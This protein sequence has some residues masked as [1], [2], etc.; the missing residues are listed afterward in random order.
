MFANPDNEVTFPISATPQSIETSEASQLRKE[1]EA[2]NGL[3]LTRFV[4]PEAIVSILKTKGRLNSVNHGGKTHFAIGL[5]RYD[6]EKMKKV[7]G[8]YGNGGASIG[9]FMV[10]PKENSQWGI[11]PTAGSGFGEELVLPPNIVVDYD[12]YLFVVPE[13]LPLVKACQ[14]REE[15]LGILGSRDTAESEVIK[16]AEELVSLRARLA[17]LLQK[18]SSSAIENYCTEI[19]IHNLSHEDKKQTS[20]MSGMF[21]NGAAGMK[22]LDTTRKMVEELEALAASV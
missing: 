16:K 15:A 8:S 2:Q 17:D 22:D 11:T 21:I 19:L 12:S 20:L 6:D 5:N 14:S 3:F 9:C 4:S 13:E 1:T 10:F 7:N 18:V